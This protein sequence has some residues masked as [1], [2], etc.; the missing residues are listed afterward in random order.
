M[1]RVRVIGVG[2]PLMGDDGLG[3]AVI[4]QLQLLALPPDIELIDAGCGGL[5]LLPLF[6]DCEQVVLIDAAEFGATAG[7]IKQLPAGQLSMQAT[8]QPHRL[9]HHFAL[10]EILALVLQQAA[11][12]EIVLFLMQAADCR[13]R[14][15][16]S[17]EVAAALPALL[18][19]ITAFLKIPPPQ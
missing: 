19:S 3:I 1:S 9:G 4:E 16:L 7:E 11:P 12:P 6:S 5:N 17:A 15:A 18:S 2:N 10:P 8:T 13:P 14:L